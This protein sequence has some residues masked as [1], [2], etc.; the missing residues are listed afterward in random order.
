MKKFGDILAVIGVPVNNRTPLVDA[1]ISS[2]HGLLTRIEQSRRL[3]SRCYKAIAIFTLN[4]LVFCAGLELAAKSAFKIRS[5]ISRSAQELVGD[6]SPREKVSYYSS[7]DWAE[8]YWYECRLS[9]KERYY[10]YVGWRRPPFNGKTI[11]IDQNGLRMTPG[12]DCRDGSF[13]VFAFGESSMW[14]TGSPDWDTI[15][16]NLQKSLEKLRQGP[17]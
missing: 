9:G 8:T 3:L 10:T 2:F 14:G 4:A 6:G 5:L 1:I 16:A 11:K 7:Q 12:A 17:V 13:K 15:P